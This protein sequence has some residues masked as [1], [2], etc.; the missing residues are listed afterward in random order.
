MAAGG[1]AADDNVIL[2]ARENYKPEDPRQGIRFTKDCKFVLLNRHE[3]NPS[4]RRK[5]FFVYD[6]TGKYGFVPKNLVKDIR[7]SPQARDMGVVFQDFEPVEP[8]ELRLRSGDI[9]EI[10][11]KAPT[12]WYNGICKGRQGWFPKDFIKDDFNFDDSGGVLAHQ[13]TVK[14]FSSCNASGGGEYL[15]FSASDFLDVVK[16]PTTGDSDWIGRNREGK[17]GKIPKNKLDERPDMPSVLFHWPWYHGDCSRDNAIALVEDKL[18]RPNHFLIRKSN[19]N[20]S[21]M[22]RVRV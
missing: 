5:L 8:Q 10:T 15:A 9:V 19:S 18:N 22:F 21:T 11:D 4:H 13:F 12:G 16:R 1:V 20:V 2:R 14:A 3:V 17:L 6:V 7:E